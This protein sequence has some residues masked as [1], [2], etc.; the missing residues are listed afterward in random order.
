MT[1]SGQN[2]WV[3]SF[4]TPDGINFDP[5]INSLGSGNA[6]GIDLLT[7]WNSRRYGLSAK[8]TF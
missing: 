6:R 4:N 8:L 7:S 5:E 1:L 2:L 3:K